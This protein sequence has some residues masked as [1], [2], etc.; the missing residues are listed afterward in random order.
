MWYM[1]QTYWYQKDPLPWDAS[2][3]LQNSDSPKSSLKATPLAS[4]WPHKLDQWEQSI[5]GEP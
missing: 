1:C 4:S 5:H 2:L 3:N